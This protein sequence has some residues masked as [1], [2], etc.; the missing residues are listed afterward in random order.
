MTITRP[1]SREEKIQ[2]ELK[3]KKKDI[4]VADLDMITKEDWCLAVG[5]F[6]QLINF[7]VD[8]QNILVVMFHMFFILTDVSSN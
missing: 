2:S 8:R 1:L 5:D 7:E 4:Q 6:Y 3:L